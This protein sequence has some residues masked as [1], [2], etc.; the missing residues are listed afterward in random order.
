M[1][2][3]ISVFGK[4]L[5]TLVLNSIGKLSC[6]RWFLAGVTLVWEDMQACCFCLLLP[7]TAGEIKLQKMHHFLAHMLLDLQIG[8]R[9]L[10]G[11]FSGGQ[12]CTWQGC[13]TL[14]WQDWD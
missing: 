2:F 12:S 9:A 13:T 10:C 7:I 8:A 5:V 14:P 6:V 1:S 3:S 4:I 11:G